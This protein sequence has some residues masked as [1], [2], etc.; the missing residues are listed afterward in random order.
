MEA[1]VQEILGQA[2]TKTAKI[3]KLIL[4]GITRTQIAELVT[5]G[6]Y[7]FVQNVYA[8]MKREGLLTQTPAQSQPRVLDFMNRRFGVEFE[9]CNVQKEVLS[10]ALNAA[11]VACEI[12]GY[13]HT[14]RAHW[15]IVHDGSLEGNNTFELVSPVLN[16]EAGI[17]ELQTVCR[18]LTECG[19]KVNKSCG[20]HVHIDATGFTLDQWKRIYINYSRLE[21]TI[22]AFMAKS[23]RSNNNA[24]SRS[25]NNINGLERRVNACSSLNEIARVFNN[26]RYYKVNPT[27]YSR[28]NTC[29]FRQ[30][31]GTVE[32]EKISNWIK[33][34]NNLV[35]LSKTSTI[36]NTELQQ[37]DFCSADMINYLT[38]RT[39]KL[40]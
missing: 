10:R 38:Q 16:G 39:L 25:L 31:G 28:H 8:K 5:N 9:A 18:V 22:D 4:L 17:S 11:G 13:N 21:A 1:R 36:N 26:D 33:F 30:H 14:T 20:T 29:E 2:G 19:A 37:L 6:N 3:Q 12:E 24:Y 7:G 32:F 23:R 27:S 34:V 15:K 35:E 40:A